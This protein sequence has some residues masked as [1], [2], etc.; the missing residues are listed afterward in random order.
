MAFLIR[1]LFNK[2]W[3]FN[4]EVSEGIDKWKRRD[5]SGSA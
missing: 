4:K 5:S 2:V 1:E 3:L